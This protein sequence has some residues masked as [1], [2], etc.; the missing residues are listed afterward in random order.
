MDAVSPAEHPFLF[1][2]L[3]QNP[4]HWGG[5]EGLK[6]GQENGNGD[7]KQANKTSDILYRYSFT[8][9]NVNI[10]CI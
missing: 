2:A 1:P 6:G 4:V 8:T 10:V 9:M 5:K 3:L 7:E